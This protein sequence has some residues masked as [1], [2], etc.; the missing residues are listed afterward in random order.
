METPLI[1]DE[2]VGKHGAYRIPEMTMCNTSR[3]SEAAR[4]FT[5]YGEYPY[6]PPHPKNDKDINY[7]DR[8]Q[9][10]AKY[11]DYKK[12]WDEEERKC[13]E[14]V[15]IPGKLLKG[16]NMEEIH[17]SPF[18]YS[19]LNF[20]QILLAN[21]PTE[22]ENLFKSK[23]PLFARQ[24]G[25]S[26]IAFPEFWDGD[27][28]YWKTIDLALELGMNVV[29]SKTR[30]VGYSYKN[31]WLNTHQYNFI[32][33]S[34]S[35]TCAYDG[36][37]L[38][39]GEGTFQMAKNYVYYLNKYTDWKKSIKSDNDKELISGYRYKGSRE[40]RGFNSKILA[41]AFEKDVSVAR[42]KKSKVIVVDEA[43]NAPNLIDF[44]SA[45][46]KGL[47]EGSITTGVMIIFGTGGGKAANWLPFKKIFYNP[48]VY[49]CLPFVNVWDSKIDN[50]TSVCGFF[51][52]RYMNL[53]PYY[54]EDGN[55]DKAGAKAHEDKMREQIQKD[56]DAEQDI[57]K[58]IAEYPYE[59]SE[60][61]KRSSSSIFSRPE[62]YDQLHLVQV[63]KELHFS[64]TGSIVR[65]GSG[66]KFVPNAD[67]PRE[68]RHPEITSYP[69]VAKEDNHGAVTIWYYPFRK[70]GIVPDNLYY[71]WHDPYDM[72]KDKKTIR[73]DTSLGAAY[74]YEAVNNLTGSMGDR[75]V[76]KLV[77]R[78]SRVDDY[79]RAL[80]LLSE[81]YNAKIWFENDRG[82]VISY[83]K[84]PVVK[85]LHM[86]CTEPD[87]DS[88]KEIQGKSGRKYGVSMGSHNG[89]RRRTALL[90]LRDWLYQTRGVDETG[91]EKMNV[92]HV[93]CERLLNELTDFNEDGNFDGISA[94]CVGMFCT[95]EILD[96]GILA[97]ERD[98]RN[99]ESIFNADVLINKML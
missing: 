12:W 33:A 93:L 30:Q 29:V 13:K 2:G 7:Y 78:P 45:T 24:T 42:G 37:Y 67:L 44:V 21:S 74:V 98:V 69:V 10:S 92:H 91:R 6:P 3:L 11:D 4:Y 23:K 36:D 55:S 48:L 59:P 60:A 25:D 96:K 70:N 80:F 50:N 61:F 31:A 51:H 99:K 57:D 34:T 62:L 95:K 20:A 84:N 88:I 97:K 63:D 17:I 75:I 18:H 39:T 81:Y 71:I 82:Q 9:D 53:K 66:L 86:L 89:L 28:Y 94:L 64:Q 49:N 38:S 43:G 22:K 79:N 76:A 16:G 54:D 58:Y 72:D 90:Y 14:G 5:K 19:Y 65:T 85:K 26:K 77:G 87:F 68:E 35:L 32:P 83:A 47:R 73:S 56:G 40:W 1:L 15:I 46:E 27:Y 41:L 52:P 8:F